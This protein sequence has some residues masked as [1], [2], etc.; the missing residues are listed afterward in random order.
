MAGRLLTSSIESSRNLPEPYK[1]R[2]S[3]IETCINAKEIEQ[4]FDL[5]NSYA[6][7]E[8]HTH[9]GFE[10]GFS[11]QPLIHNINRN[12]DQGFC[13]LFEQGLS[14]SFPCNTCAEITKS[15]VYLLKP[16]LQI[17]IIKNGVL[18]G[19]GQT[20]CRGIVHVMEPE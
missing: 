20:G 3:F 14:P 2:G 15:W 10:G 13:A 7:L 11:H 18:G 8:G 12:G 19:K 17:W 6:L 9:M 16:L 5:S 1:S 4:L